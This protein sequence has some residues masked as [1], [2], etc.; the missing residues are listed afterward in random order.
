MEKTKQTKAST[1]QYHSEVVDIASGGKGYPADN[2]LSSGKVELKYMTTKEEDILTSQN[3]IKQGIV[4]DKLL[5][6]IILT[7]GVNVNDMLVGDKNS[8]LV[9]AGILAYGPEYTVTINHPNSGEELTQTF[10]LTDCEFRELPDDVDYSDKSF[11]FETPITKDTIQWD[12]VDGVTEVE[13][14]KTMDVMKKKMGK[15][16]AVTTRLK[17]IVKSVNGDSNKLAVNSYIDNMLARDALA[18][19]R[20]VAR[21]SPDI[22]ME[23]EVEWEGETISVVIPM[24]IEFFWPKGGE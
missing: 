4:I 21:V 11:E 5:E 24:D 10:N 2:P 7:E 1:P 15:E 16:S 18:F 14:N 22:I 3:L 8:V 23:Q 19:R 17:S 9:A 6:S 12:L 13:I 20:E